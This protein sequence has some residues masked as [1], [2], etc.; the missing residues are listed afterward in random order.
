MLFGNFGGFQIQAGF[1][2]IYQGRFS[3]A[4]MTRKYTYVFL[5]HLLY[6]VY[7][8]SR[9]GRDSYTFIS[10]FPIK[11]G[12]KFDFQQF[13]FV[14]SVYFI[15]KKDGANV[16]GFRRYQKPIDKGGKGGRIV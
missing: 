12:Q 3:S 14:I 1:K 5:H 15:E 13:I 4:A 11:G 16:I 6:L 8:F 7:V 2:C 9:K 10:D